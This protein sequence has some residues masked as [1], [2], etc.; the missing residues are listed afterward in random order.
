MVLFMSMCQVESFEKKCL[1]TTNVLAEVHAP[2]KCH[3][4]NSLMI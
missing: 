2:I 3:N 4:H 1:Y